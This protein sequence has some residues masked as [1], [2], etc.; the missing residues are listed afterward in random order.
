MG[1]RKDFLK[2]SAFGVWGLVLGFSTNSY[3]QILGTNDR[4]KVA[5]IGCGRRVP[6]YYESLSDQ[7]NTELSYIC[8]VKKSQRER[9]A[10]DLKDKIPNKPT[11]TED[12]RVVYVDLS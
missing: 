3:I 2:K 6:A 1:T 8:D 12:L 5:F 10:N 7:Y 4:I 9:V 11:L